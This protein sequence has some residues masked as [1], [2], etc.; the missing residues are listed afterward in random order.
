MKS[1]E[2]LKSD[3]GEGSI[4]F[5][6]PIFNFGSF[7]PK[8]AR[9]SDMFRQELPKICPNSNEYLLAKSA[10]IQPRTSSVKFAKS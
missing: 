8:D 3:K 4:H 5:R 1:A 2:L 6:D 9:K 10:S 7:L